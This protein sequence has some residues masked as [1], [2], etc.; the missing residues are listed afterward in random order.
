MISDPFMLLSMVNMKLRDSYSDLDELCAAEDYDK[1]QLIA[2][3]HA[4]GFD[5]LPATNQ[6]R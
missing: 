1:E 5:Y 2:T 6:F 4:A 3:L